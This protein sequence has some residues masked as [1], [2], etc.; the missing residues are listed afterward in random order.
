MKGNI[1][2]V[3]MPAA[4]KSTAGVILAK[5]MAYDFIDTDLI[6][7]RQCGKKLQEIIDSEGL[8]AFLKYEE[9]ALMLVE[10][11]GPTVIATGGSA[12]F[13]E[14]G[15][16]HLKKNGI[17]VYINTDEKELA[18]RLAGIKNRGIAA[19]PGQ[20]ISE[21]MREREPFYKKW[22]DIE[23]TGVYEAEELAGLVADIVSKSTV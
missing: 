14:K 3:G 20:T 11:K 17:C 21:I 2:L 16:A 8:E 9:D 18:E 6:I 5:I 7:Q 22:A 1:I 15:M 4:G 19:L 23:T 10:T 12:V 13:S